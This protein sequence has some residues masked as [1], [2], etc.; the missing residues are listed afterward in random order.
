MF[1]IGEAVIDDTVG[2]VSFCCDLHAC[3]GACCCI[4][5]GRGAP[6]DDGEV[7]E[8]EKAYPIV[9]QYLSEKSTQTIE[10][11][12]LVDGGPGDYATACVDE[13]EC[14]FVF[15]DDGIAKCSFERAWQEG[16]ISWRKPI[17]C[18]LFPIR[19]HTMEG[20]YLRYVQI[21]ECAGGRERGAVEKVKLVEFLR[22]PLIR[23]YGEDWYKQLLAACSTI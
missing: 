9:K 11:S 13:K 12:G 3:K 4:S 6:L 10:T 17:S 19:F 8:I 14:V 21:E 18:H 23:R 2:H 7:R 15:F 16:K 20:E 1:V 5:G 22:E